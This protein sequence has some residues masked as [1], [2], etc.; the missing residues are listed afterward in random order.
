[1]T[2]RHRRKP[3]H[4]YGGS[5]WSPPPRPALTVSPLTVVG[6]VAERCRLVITQSRRTMVKLRCR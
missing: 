6:I 3:A 2:L 1:M 4:S 5:P